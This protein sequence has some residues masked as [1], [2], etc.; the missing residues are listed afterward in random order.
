MRLQPQQLSQTAQGSRRL[1]LKCWML[2]VSRTYHH[3]FF[4][5]LENWCSALRCTSSLISP[6]LRGTSLDNVSTIIVF[7]LISDC[8]GSMCQA[9]SSLVVSINEKSIRSAARTQT[10]CHCSYALAYSW[11]YLVSSQDI[12]FTDESGILVSLR[13][14]IIPAAHRKHTRYTVSNGAFLKLRC[15]LDGKLISLL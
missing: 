4:L 10:N 13:T 1:L 9:V 6:L 15:E 7:S 2:E 5:R 3:S 14:S 8:S 11:L 12:C